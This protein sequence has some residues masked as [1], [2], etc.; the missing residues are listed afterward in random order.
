MHM[1]VILR[2]LTT[3]R[4]NHC[5]LI[6]TGICGWD[7]SLQRYIIITSSILRYHL[8]LLKMRNSGAAGDGTGK[9][10]AVSPPTGEHICSISHSGV[11]VWTKTDP[12][13][14]PPLTTVH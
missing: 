14:F 11:S 1:S 3:F 8:I 13:R 5:Q 12:W 2:H 10:A 9:W 6:L 4:K 7:L